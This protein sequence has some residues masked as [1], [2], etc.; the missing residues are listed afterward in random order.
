MG[1]RAR[2]GRRDAGANHAPRRTGRWPEDASWPGR[3]LCEAQMFSSKRVLPEHKTAVRPTGRC[4]RHWSGCAFRVG[5][6][7]LRILCSTQAARKAGFRNVFD[8]SWRRLLR[9]R[10]L[11]VNVGLTAARAGLA[12]FLRIQALLGRLG[13]KYE[14]FCLP[15]CADD[16][17]DRVL[18]Q[19][20]RAGDACRRHPGLR[21]QKAEERAR[22][23]FHSPRADLPDF[24]RADKLDYDKYREIRF[25]RDQAL[26]AADKLPFHRG[27]FSSGLSL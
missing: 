2:G 26:W 8:G 23:P 4:I 16:R 9:P 5:I 21:G 6:G 3:A 1:R 24:L 14:A 13:R 12:H 18:L 15:K 7:S 19:G 17:G 25:R 22:K 20:L 27:I 11:C 10:H